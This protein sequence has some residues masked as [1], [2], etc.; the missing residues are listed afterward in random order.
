MVVE[1]CNND[2]CVCWFRFSS[3]AGPKM[4]EHNKKIK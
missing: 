2:R 4:Q 3:S 1:E